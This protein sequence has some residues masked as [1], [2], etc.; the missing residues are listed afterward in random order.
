[1]C[2]L[3]LFTKRDHCPSLDHRHLLLI[4]EILQEKSIL[5]EIQKEWNKKKWTC[6][7]PSAIKLTPLSPK[8][9]SFFISSEMITS[10]RCENQ[11]GHHTG[12]S[13]LSLQVNGLFSKGVFLPW[14]PP[15]GSRSEG[16]CY[17][18]QGTQP[19][20]DWGQEI[21]APSPTGT[22][23]TLILNISTV[24]RQKYRHLSQNWRWWAVRGSKQLIYWM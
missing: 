11:W 23:I 24:A 13:Y 12:M 4:S 1:V 5:K 19:C 6:I 2:S 10:C 17:Y 15:G 8:M 20:G 22:H 21:G 3:H 18:S 7:K 14:L 16:H 9:S